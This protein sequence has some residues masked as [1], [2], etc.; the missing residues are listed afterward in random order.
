[1][2]AMFAIE[3]DVQRAMIERVAAA[4]AAGK[5]IIGREDA[6]NEGDQRDALLAVVAQR[7]DIP[8]RIAVFRD[9]A[10]EARSAIRLAAAIR[11]DSA[12]I[13]TPGPGWALPPAR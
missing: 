10:V 3:R 8:P 11:P 1:M 2:L 13:G 9:G 6:T 12:A 4:E 5:R 7:V